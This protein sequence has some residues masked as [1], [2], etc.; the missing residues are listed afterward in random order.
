MN[1]HYD[2]VGSAFRGTNFPARRRGSIPGI[3]LGNVLP[4][5]PPSDSESALKSGEVLIFGSGRYWDDDER[6]FEAS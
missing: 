6:A 3:C 5:A 4:V 2:I 1:T